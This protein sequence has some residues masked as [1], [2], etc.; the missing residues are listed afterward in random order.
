M[1]MIAYLIG[2]AVLEIEHQ[3]RQ[4]SLSAQILWVDLQTLWQDVLILR[5]NLVLM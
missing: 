5:A 1:T 2:R 4:I 3:C